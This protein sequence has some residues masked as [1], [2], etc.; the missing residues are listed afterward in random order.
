MNI[1][2]LGT[3]YIG[4]I[5][6]ACLAEMGNEVVCVDRDEALIDDLDN[7]RLP[8]YEPGLEDLVRR[9]CMGRRL[10]FSTNFAKAIENS[11]IIYLG[12]SHGTAVPEDK[13][14]AAAL[15]ALAREVGLVLNDY[16]IIVNKSNAPI[17]TTQKIRDALAQTLASRGEVFAFDVVVDPEFIKQG[18]AIDDFMRPDRVV[19]GCESPAA[20]ELMQELYAPFVRTNRPVIV[21][22]LI[23][24]E[25]IKFAANAFLATKISFMNELAHICAA[26][27]ADI[28]LI[29]RGL[30]SDSRIGPL[31]LFPGLGYGGL[32]FSQGIRGLIQTAKAVAYTP[33][34]LEAAEAI[35]RAQRQYFLNCIRRHFQGQVAGKVFGAW[36]LSFKPW[37]DDVREAPALEVLAALVQEGAFIK[38]YDP[39]AV[40]TARRFFG[41][42]HPAISYAADMYEAADGADALLIHTDWTMFRTPDLNRLRARLRAP[43]IFD[44]RNLYIPEKMAQRGFIYYYIGGSTP[45]DAAAAAPS[46]ALPSQGPGRS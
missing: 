8:V 17:G 22:D 3:D 15:V 9:N 31:F 12:F 5:T 39:Q 29:R 6:A 4:L 34:L 40:H 43:V 27:G 16:K 13:A 23:S 38:A 33:R 42:A 19:I 32:R 21:M 44:G 30:G 46:A 36:G 24:A 45:C 7:Y 1:A 25:L 2:V 35:N 28:N 18:T 41:P 11:L 20:A 37:T 14:E 10:F 26:V